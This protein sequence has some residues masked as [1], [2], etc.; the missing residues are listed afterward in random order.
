MKAEK[1][2]S[3][4]LCCRDCIFYKAGGVYR[5]QGWCKNPKINHSVLGKYF[6][7]ECDEFKEKKR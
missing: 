5:G 4:G 2:G 1:E 6:A 3:V 7:S